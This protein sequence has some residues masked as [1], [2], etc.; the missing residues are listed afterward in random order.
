MVLRRLSYKTETNVPHCVQGRTVIRD[1]FHAIPSHTLPLQFAV[2]CV[3]SHDSLAS[4]PQNVHHSDQNLDVLVVVG[5]ALFVAKSELRSLPPAA[6]L[7]LPAIQIS[8][9]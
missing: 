9:A 7:K 4:G 8:R 2:P 6:P 1:E 3:M 5:V